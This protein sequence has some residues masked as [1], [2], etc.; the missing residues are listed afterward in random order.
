MGSLPPQA[1]PAFGHG[2]VGRGGHAGGVCVR[3]VAV[4]VLLGADR[5]VRTL[6][7]FCWGQIVL[8]RAAASCMVK[9]GGGRCPAGLP[10]LCVD[11]VNLGKATD[12]CL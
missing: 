10:G 7:G 5:L 9:S 3:A 6:W 11:P 2:L 12:G 1:P 4:E 8:F